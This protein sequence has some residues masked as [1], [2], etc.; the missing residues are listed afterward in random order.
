VDEALKYITE[1]MSIQGNRMLSRLENAL[2]FVMYIPNFPPELRKHMFGR[3]YDFLR[4]SI[5]LLR[6]IGL[7]SG[8]NGKFSAR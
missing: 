7:V 6:D 4:S 3:C 5:Q 8:N 1:P 2:A